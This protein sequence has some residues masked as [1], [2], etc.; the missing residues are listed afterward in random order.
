MQSLFDQKCGPGV[1]GSGAVFMFMMQDPQAGPAS[2][3]QCLCRE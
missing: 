3:G 1:K 2:G